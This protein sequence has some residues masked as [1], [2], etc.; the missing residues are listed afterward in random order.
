MN[1][2]W[3]MRE[4]KV[5]KRIVLH[6]QVP[7][8]TGAKLLPANLRAGELRVFLLSPADAG[9]RRAKMLFRSGASFELAERL[10]T[11][12]VPLAEAFSFMSPLYFRGKL[13]Y[14]SA[15]AKAPAGIPG[16]LI[17]TPC[18]GL[19]KPETIVGLEELEEISNERVAV[20]NPKYRDPLER[21]LG[22][23]SQ[24]IG[25]QVRVVLLGSIATRKYIPL[26]IEKLGDRLMVPKEFVGLGNM[27]RGALLLRC[28]RQGHELEYVATRA[29][30]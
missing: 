11:T 8:A 26:L 7:G 19:L 5:S 4:V 30:F 25:S 2:T 15:F 22:L 24:A 18:R 13:S 27:S 12:G 23:L 20:D 6:G 28:T 17:I 21:D 1:Q 16:S 3:S 14:A 10:R 29:I 9:G